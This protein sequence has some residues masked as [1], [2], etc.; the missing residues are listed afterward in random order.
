ML[1]AV[2][3]GGAVTYVLLKAVDAAVG[4]DEVLHGEDLGRNP[5][6]Y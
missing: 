5:P 6:C 2:S 3:Y 1:A 4:L